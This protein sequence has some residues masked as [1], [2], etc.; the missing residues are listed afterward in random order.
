MYI[1]TKFNFYMYVIKCDI[2]MMFPYYC[3][4][5]C[6]Y[7]IFNICPWWATIWLNWIAL[8]IAAYCN[9]VI[10][11]RTIYRRYEKNTMTIT[12]VCM[13][14][15]VS[16][17]ICISSFLKLS[18]HH[19]WGKFT[20]NKTIWTT[21]KHFTVLFFLYWKFL[22]LVETGIWSVSVIHDLPSENQPSSHI[23]FYK[24]NTS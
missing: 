22:T 15:C 20:W 6:H 4:A 18:T 7:L 11:K 3:R 9:I 16:L 19:C 8:I 24:I 21:L 12:C 17:H 2:N 14:V 1:C 10:Y 23:R 5:Y 13:C